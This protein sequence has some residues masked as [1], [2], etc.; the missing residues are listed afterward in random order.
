MKTIMSLLLLPIM[1]LAQPYAQHQN[2]RFDIKFSMDVAMESIPNGEIGSADLIDVSIELFVTVE[3]YVWE[4]EINR[5]RPK[6]NYNGVMVNSLPK[7][8]NTFS[9]VGWPTIGS[10]DQRPEKRLDHLLTLNDSKFLKEDTLFDG[11]HPVRYQ[12]SKLGGVENIPKG[13]GPRIRL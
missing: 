5:V 3:I 12:Q 2:E 6:F 1:V 4:M 9:L 10:E 11:L 8:L 7:Y 13:F